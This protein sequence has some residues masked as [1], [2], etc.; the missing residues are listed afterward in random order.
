MISLLTLPVVGLPGGKTRGSVS[1]DIIIRNGENI[2]AKEVED[3]LITHPL[4]REIAVVGVSDAETGERVCAY[5]VP[6]EGS[7]PT[8]EDLCAL[9]ENAQIARQKYPEYIVLI[10]SLPRTAPLERCRSSSFERMRRA[11]RFK[12]RCAND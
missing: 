12:G 3:L 2:A 8:L 5:V 4:I 6:A 9:L 10:D 7:G 1:R 11:G